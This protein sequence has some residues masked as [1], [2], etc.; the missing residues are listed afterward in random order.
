MPEATI[1]F[2]ESSLTV[3]NICL[4]IIMFGVALDIR[5]A[6]FTQLVGQKKAIATGL[7]A[8]IVLLPLLTLL[9]ISVLP[10]SP[11]MALGMLLV[12]CCPGGNVSNFFSQMARGHVA[13]SVTLTAFTS[14]GAFFITPLSFFLW[15]SILPSLATE[16]KSFEI[17]LVSLLVN[18]V[19]ILLLPLVLGMSVASHLPRITQK[20]AQPVRIVSMFILIVF[21]I[22]AVLN[23]QDAFAVHLGNVFWIVLLHNGLALAAAYYFSKAL[24]NT[25]DVNRTVAIE[26]GIQNSGLA[27]ILIFTFFNGNTAMAVVAAWWGVWHLISGLA[28]ASIMRKHKIVTQS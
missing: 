21:I 15:G 2:S 9:L 6:H 13:L 3:L 17:D 8:Q 20:I 19:A 23:N 24:K 7:F 18:M 10:I 28:F 26:T 11:G 12:A 5:W 14:L 22:A 1:Q 16:I 4:A 27:L 25:E